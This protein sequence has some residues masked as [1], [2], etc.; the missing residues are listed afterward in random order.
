M[1]PFLHSPYAPW[2]LRVM[3]S[4][5]APRR[6]CLKNDRFLDG[7]PIGASFNFGNGSGR[8]T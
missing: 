1:P 5:E 8:S 4:Q 2:Q 3:K 7:S 6:T